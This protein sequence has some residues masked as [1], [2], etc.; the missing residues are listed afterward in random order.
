MC[1]MG[2]QQVT[3]CANLHNAAFADG[4][5]IMLCRLA[6][7]LVPEHGVIIFNI[8]C[9]Q[10]VIY[11]SRHTIVISYGKFVMLKLLC[12]HKTVIAYLLD[13]IIFVYI[14]LTPGKAAPHAFFSI[15]NVAKPCCCARNNPRE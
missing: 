10:Q 6:S 9:H 14:A 12:S 13:N 15:H 8:I 2:W 4:L 7:G 11:L 3:V 1:A 5:R